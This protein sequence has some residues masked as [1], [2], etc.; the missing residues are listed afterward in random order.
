MTPYFF[1]LVK[2]IMVGHIKSH[3]HLGISWPLNISSY[4]DNELG[5]LYI[6]ENELYLWDKWKKKVSLYLWNRGSS[7][8]V[9]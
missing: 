1:P 3:C 6:N 8:N 2:N 9:Y 4:I 5:E 7:I